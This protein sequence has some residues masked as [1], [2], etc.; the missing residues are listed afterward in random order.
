LATSATRAPSRAAR[1]AIARP[2][3]R[4]PPDM[5]MVRPESESMD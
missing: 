5:K 2:M 1:K 4:L 3:P